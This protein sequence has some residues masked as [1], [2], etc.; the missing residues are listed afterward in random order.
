MAELRGKPVIRW[1]ESTP[2]FH[3]PLP[4][5][6]E[7]VERSATRSNAMKRYTTEAAT[8]LTL[9]MLSVTAPS[10]AAGQGILDRLRSLA[11]SS[12]P[13]NDEGWRDIERYVERYKDRPLVLRPTRG[14]HRRVHLWNDPEG[15][16]YAVHEGDGLFP[17]TE[18]TRV[19]VRDADPRRITSRSTSRAPTAGAAGSASTAANPRSPCSGAGWTRSSRRRPPSRISSATS[20]TP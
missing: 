7:T 19:R 5:E 18:P 2:G 9:A 20:P 4:R 15:A 1:I 11:E 6:S 16:A 3:N 10:P 13:N 17:V 8:V 14:E 12:D